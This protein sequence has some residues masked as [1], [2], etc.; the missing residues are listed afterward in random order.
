MKDEVDV[1]GSRPYLIN[2]PYALL[3]E[4]TWKKISHTRQK[5]S[6]SACEQRISLLYKKRSIIIILSVCCDSES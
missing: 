5:R 4:S 1:Q 6:E 3:S 2:S